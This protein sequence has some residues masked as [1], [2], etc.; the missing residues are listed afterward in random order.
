MN[1]F[2]VASILLLC[3]LGTFPAP[4]VAQPTQAPW[5]PCSGMNLVDQIFPTT[6]PEETH[7]RLCWQAIPRNGVVINWAFFRKSPT[8]PWIQLFWDAR[9]SD[10]FVP[11]HSGSPRFYDMSGFTFQLVPVGA[12]DCPAAH[13]G[14]PLGGT[15]C[16]EIRDRGLAWKDYSQV[17]RGEGPVLGTG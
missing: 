4:G 16:K 15:V 14:M 1:R 11:Y 5:M 7:W 10:I 13:G 6:G 17:R 3:L 2:V 9:V 12:K 8:S